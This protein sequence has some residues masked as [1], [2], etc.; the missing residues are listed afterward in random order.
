MFDLWLVIRGFDWQLSIFLYHVIQKYIFYWLSQ[1]KSIV[2][3]LVKG[4]QQTNKQSFP[5][6]LAFYDVYDACTFLTIT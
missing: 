1:Q 6:L 2:P 5:L 3:T 4:N